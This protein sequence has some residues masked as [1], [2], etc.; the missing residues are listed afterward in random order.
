MDPGNPLL[1]SSD[2]GVIRILEEHGATRGKHA[3]CSRGAGRGATVDF[4]L[5]KWCPG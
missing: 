2:E 1:L 3:I 5:L 4:I